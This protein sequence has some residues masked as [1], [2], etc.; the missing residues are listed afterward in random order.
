MPPC[1]AVRHP[2]LRPAARA[3]R[4]P[5]PLV[6]DGRS[7]HRPQRFRGA[8]PGAAG[9]AGF[10][11]RRTSASRACRRAGHRAGRRGVASRTSGR[12]ESRT[13][14]RRHSRGRR[15]SQR[16][17]SAAAGRACRSS[18][19]PRAA[20]GSRRHHAGDSGAR[21]GSRSPRGRTG[22]KAR[23]GAFKYEPV[24][25]D[26]RR[27]P[28]LAPPRRARP[29]CPSRYRTSVPLQPAQ[30]TRDRLSS[31]PIGGTVA[32]QRHAPRSG[33]R[34]PGRTSAPTTRLSHLAGREAT[35]SRATSPSTTVPPG[36]GRS[37]Q[38]GRPP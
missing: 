11:A 2:S 5:G 33:R 28:D 4:R 1:H 14:C 22:R 30:P 31:R 17:G 29:C 27:H 35:E 20:R 21:R 18:L 8:A 24:N 15:S 34:L 23:C 19:A 9:A 3:R 10:A 26:S 16:S 38:A 12:A 37:L 6:R 25:A 32:A 7:R 13:S 36:T